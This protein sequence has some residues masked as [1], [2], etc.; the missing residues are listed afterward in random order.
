MPWP[1]G[2]L[3]HPHSGP[4]GPR[5]PEGPH[6]H[7]MRPQATGGQALER[8]NE[9]L[10]SRG[11]HSAAFFSEPSW[12]QFSEGKQVI[13]EVGV[14]N[15]QL[16]FLSQEPELNQDAADQCPAPPPEGA[17]CPNGADGPC[18]GS[19]K[20]CGNPSRPTTLWGGLP[21]KGWIR[22]GTMW[23]STCPVPPLGAFP[24]P[25]L[26]AKSQTSAERCP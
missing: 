2:S 22:S 23:L 9:A 16:H 14:N 3:P 8:S 10:R 12:G 25:P 4:R 24:M 6:P 20:A 21:W 19:P 26:T 18:E 5:A 11:L 13:R 15:W 17:A 7:P 1:S